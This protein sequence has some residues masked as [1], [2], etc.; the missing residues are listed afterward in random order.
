MWPGMFWRCRSL[1]A[2]KPERRLQ[3]FRCKA[4]TSRNP[5]IMVRMG[6]APVVKAENECGSIG[7][8]EIMALR[9]SVSVRIREL[10]ISAK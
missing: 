5:M 3:C 6:R 10:I 9:T 4:T 7:N 1:Q 2:G 8:K